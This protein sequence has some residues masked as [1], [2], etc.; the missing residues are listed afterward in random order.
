MNN[1]TLIVTCICTC[2]D[3]LDIRAGMRFFYSSCPYSK[4]ITKHA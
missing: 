3:H 1:I 2:G 4:W